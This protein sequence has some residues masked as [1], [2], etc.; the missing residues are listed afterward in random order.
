MSFDVSAVNNSDSKLKVV[1][2]DTKYRSSQLQFCWFRAKTCGTQSP[3]KLDSG[4]LKHLFSTEG[5]L[6]LNFEHH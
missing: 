5:R 2:R 1:Y 6:F 4:P 3:D